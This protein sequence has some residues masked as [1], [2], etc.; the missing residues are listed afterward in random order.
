[1]TALSQMYEKPSTSNKVFLMKK[2]F[3]IKIS[4]GDGVA[5][6]LNKFNMVICQ[7]SSVG[8]NFNDEVRALV[9]L[10]SFAREFRWFGDGL[11][12][13]FGFGYTQV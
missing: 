10:F 3:N 7:L 8:I 1:M 5:E 6:H 9:L 4:E 2:L 12:K 13:F 11:E